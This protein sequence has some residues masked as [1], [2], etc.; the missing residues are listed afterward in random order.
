LLPRLLLL[1][2]SFTNSGSLRLHQQ[3][4]VSP[5]FSAQNCRLKSELLIPRKQ[6]HH[7][8]TR[9]I[10]PRFDGKNPHQNPRH[11]MTATIVP[12]FDKNIP[13]QETAPKRPARILL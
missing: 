9:I 11:E 8:R 3:G 13:H 1:H 12:A 6:P 10:V 7:H 5:D 4:D 2:Y